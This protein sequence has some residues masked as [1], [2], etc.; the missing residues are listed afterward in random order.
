MIV[1]LTI[2]AKPYRKALIVIQFFRRILPLSSSS[3]VSLSDLTATVAAYFAILISSTKRE[4]EC[5]VDSIHH[6]FF[7][8]DNLQGGRFFDSSGKPTM[9]SDLDNRAADIA[10]ITFRSS[11]IASDINQRFP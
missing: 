9:V 4:V 2:S 7:H 8:V 5:I 10:F 6:V 3:S 1:P 11:V